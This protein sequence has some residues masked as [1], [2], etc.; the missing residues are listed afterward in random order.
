MKGVIEHFWMAGRH[1]AEARTR[2]ERED[3]LLGG[4][5]GTPSAIC[6]K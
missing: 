1:G 4:F 6:A 2:A 5:D 3:Q